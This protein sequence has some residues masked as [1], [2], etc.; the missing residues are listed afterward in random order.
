MKKIVIG[1]MVFAIEVSYGAELAS[2]DPDVQPPVIVDELEIGGFGPE[3]VVV[4]IASS[5]G[6][7]CIADETCVE[8]ITD[9]IRSMITKEY[10]ISKYEITFD[11]YEVFSEATGRELPEDN[12]WGRGSR[13]VIFVAWKDALAY[14]DWLTDQTGFTYRLPSVI[15][16]EHAAR[17]G[18]RTAYWWG[19]ELGVNRTN[20]S[21]CRSRWSHLK[22]APVG[23]FPANPWG[24]HDMHGNVGE[25]T[26]D[27]AMRKRWFSLTRR[28]PVKLNKLS[29]EPKFFRNCEWVRL[30]GST[31]NATRDSLVLWKFDRGRAYMERPVVTYPERYK[32]AAIGIRVVREM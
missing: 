28:F 32:G 17:A 5:K 10:A 1:I 7:N 21:D 26:Q 29:A 9:I 22:T 8:T 31:W 18:T 14:A 12:G 16:W 20:C 19:Q 23:S 30:K 2:E 13:P 25:F 15:E 4:P 3:L 11:D 27:C 6:E 24:I